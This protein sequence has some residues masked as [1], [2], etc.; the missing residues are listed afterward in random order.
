MNTGQTILTIGALVLLGS[1]IVTVNRSSLSHG[2][3]LQQTE[4]GVYA[5]SLAMGMI[6]EATGK[7][8][9][10]FTAPDAT[11]ETDV[12]TSTTQLTAV[13]SLGKEGSETYPDFDDFDDYNSFNV[14]PRI[15]YVPGVDTMKIRCEVGYVK[16]TNPDVIVN[17]KTWHKK[18][19]VYVTG[20]VTQDTVKVSTIFSYWWFR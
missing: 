2:V 15:V 1:T 9:D 5:I 11:G 4:I 8:F 18:M 19:T 13:T 10:E 17:E 3:I 6:E 14:N 16:E 12:A 7:A 20:T